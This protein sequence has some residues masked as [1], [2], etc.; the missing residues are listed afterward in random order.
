[1]AVLT[2][3][4]KDG[5]VS[6]GGT[7]QYKLLTS[8]DVIVS[9]IIITHRPITGKTGLYRNAVSIG[10]TAVVIDGLL[11]SFK[12]SATSQTII[13]RIMSR[14]EID[15]PCAPGLY[16]YGIAFTTHITR[17]INSRNFIVIQGANG[18][19]GDIKRIGG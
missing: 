9:K 14:L 17:N 18:E 4:I 3:G 10:E 13:I 5:T 2:L 11:N 16:A 15:P 12:G 19:P 7:Y 8:R 6:P 1:M